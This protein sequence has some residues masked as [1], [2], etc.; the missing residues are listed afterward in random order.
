[1]PRRTTAAAHDPAQGLLGAVV[2]RRR[3]TLLPGDHE[4]L[5]ERALRH[6]VGVPREPRRRRGPRMTQ[7]AAAR[8]QLARQ[9]SL[10]PT[11]VLMCGQ[12][13]AFLGTFFIPVV[14]VRIFDPTVFGTYKQLFLV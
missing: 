10:R 1:M 5:R 3:G 14:L 2:L 4:L 12:G 13:L 9:S 11:L 6:G 8:Q 7:P